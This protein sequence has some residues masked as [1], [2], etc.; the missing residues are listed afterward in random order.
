MTETLQQLH[1]VRNGEGT[2]A[3]D[4]FPEGASG[5][6]RGLQLYLERGIETGSGLGAVLEGDLWKAGNTLDSNNWKHLRELMGWIYNN[7][8]AICYG[9]KEKVAK[10]ISHRGAEGYEYEYTTE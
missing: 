5:L 7:P 6:K 9:S 4:R 10:W 3:W 2:T 1:T 8:P